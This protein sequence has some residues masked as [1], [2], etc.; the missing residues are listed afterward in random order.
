MPDHWLLKALS[1]SEFCSPPVV[2]SVELL[3]CNRASEHTQQAVD[4]FKGDIGWIMLKHH[5][6]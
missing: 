3:K 4:N 1:M 2:R 5:R 6:N